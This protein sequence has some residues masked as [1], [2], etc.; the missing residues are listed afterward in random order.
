M[1]T[2][3]YVKLQSLK[4]DRKGIAALEYGILGAVVLG[5]LVTAINLV[6]GDITTI[7]SSIGTSLTSP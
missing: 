3:A 5:A 7:F 6:K 2:Y 1:L 4:S